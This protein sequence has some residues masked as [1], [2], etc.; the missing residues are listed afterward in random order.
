MQL[1]ATPVTPLAWQ[2]S[3]QVSL[4]PNVAAA[5]PHRQAGLEGPRRLTP[6]HFFDLIFELEGWYTDESAWPKD[7]SLATFLEWF[8]VEFST[9]VVDLVDAPLQREEWD[10]PNA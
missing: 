4:R 9:M 8:D 10:V 6:S 5:E 1:T 7:R 2:A 3:R